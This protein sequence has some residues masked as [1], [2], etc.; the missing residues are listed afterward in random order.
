MADFTST[1][2]LSGTSDTGK[3]LNVSFTAT[4]ENVYEFVK[5]SG[6]TSNPDTLGSLIQPPYDMPF[7][8]IAAQCMSGIG[9]MKIDNGV[10]SDSIQ[11]SPGQFMVFCGPYAFVKDTNASATTC[12]LL[13]NE[14]RFDDSSA[15]AKIDYIALKTPVS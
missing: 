4:I 5:M 3:A 2:T 12:N 7:E 10:T 9:S 6:A 1:L 13:L 15:G 14:V 11:L 8:F